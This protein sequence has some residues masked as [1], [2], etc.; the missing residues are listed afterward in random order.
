M[1]SH[2]G[3]PI[4]I[5]GAA[6]SGTKFLRDT[7]NASRTLAAT[8]YDLNF[9]WRTGNESFPSDALTV[10][11]FRPDVGDRIVRGLRRAAGLGADDSR[12]LVEKTVSNALRVDY[13]ERVFPGADFIHIVRDGR[14]VTA[15]SMTQWQRPV[16]LRYL[17]RKLRSFPLSNYRY[18]FWYLANR[19][20]WR[21]GTGQEPVWGV[22]Y[23]GIETD[24][25]SHPLAVVCA[26]QWLSCVRAVQRARQENAGLRIREIRYEEL[27]ASESSVSSLAEWLALPDVDRVMERYRATVRPGSGSSWQALVPERDTG[28]VLTQIE[29][30][31]HELGYA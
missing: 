9:V 27:I 4:I 22:R 3:R 23:P 25:S 2:T 1:E 13:V 26:K 6:R 30:M 17:A 10:D 18:A 29:P 28:A 5:L 14:D 19:L 20:R 16:D 12:R 8:P 11:L 21:P 31:L 15:S 7:L 24:L